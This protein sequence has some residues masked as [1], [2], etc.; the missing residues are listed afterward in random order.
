VLRLVE[1]IRATAARDFP[2]DV[3]LVVLYGSHV[4]RTAGPHSD[5]DCFFVPR[6]ERGLA[7]ARTFIIDGIG[8]DIFPLRWER[9]EGLADL[10]EP[11][12]PLLGDSVVLHA[13]SPAE[14]ARFLGL[15]ARLQ[16]NLADE[17]LTHHRAVE[18]LGRARA[19]WDGTAALDDVGRLRTQA[20]LVAL[21]LAQAV[22]FANGTYF[23]HG[24]K[25]LIDD[26]AGLSTPSG[27]LPLF[28]GLAAAP[29][30]GAVL[31]RTGALLAATARFLEDDDAGSAPPLPARGAAVVDVHTLAHVYEEISSSFTKV[32]V[33]CDAGDP[34]AAFLAAVLLQDCLDDEVPVAVGL[35]GLLEAHDPADLSRLR[36]RLDAAEATLVRAIESGGAV[37]ER[38]PDLGAFL[39]AQRHDAVS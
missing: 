27:F 34:V 25:R 2:D 15:R 5:I 12:M 35:P 3:A 4:T 30:A 36:S 26:L 24:P 23:H 16:A 19:R 39:A 32:R 8:Y 10:R 22:A 33:A 38:Y 18:R 6:T 7:F 29:D 9:V 31:A 28:L 21:E 17:E 1:W 13:A 11:L 20:G 14:E 37:I